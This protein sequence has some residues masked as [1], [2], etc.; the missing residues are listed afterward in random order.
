MRVVIAG[1]HGKIALR[2]ARQL[3]G[4]RD[5]AIGLVRNPEHAADVREAGAEPIL[6]DLEGTSAGALAEHL[7]GADAVVFAAGAGPG[8]GAER[9]AS[10]DRDAAILLADAARLAG[11]RR[12]LMVSADGVDREPPPGTDDVF[13]AYLRAKREADA[14]LS[15]RDDLAWTILRPGRLTDEPGLGR[16]EL[17]RDGGGESTRDDVAWA[18]CALLD[19][20]D[21][22]GLTLSMR[23]GGLPIAQAV[24][25]A[26]DRTNNGM[27]SGRRTDLSGTEVSWGDER[28]PPYQDGP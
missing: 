26:A 19:E 12:Y 13:A 7:A 14:H 1:G 28:V 24:A 10:V 18:L 27:A 9:K 20:P 25:G 22:A 23:S 16:I 6:V 5:A 8:S 21:T 3:A 15:Q 17:G 11:V 2:L 4:R